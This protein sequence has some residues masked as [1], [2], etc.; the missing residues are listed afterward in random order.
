MGFSIGSLLSGLAPIAGAFLGG[1]VGLAIGT[2]V[3]SAFAPSPRRPS[4]QVGPTV[5]AASK[6]PQLL[7]KGAAGVGT[8]V[9]M[10]ELLKIARENSGRRVTSKIIRD[11]VRV[12]G[13]EVTAATFGL[14]TED[15]CRI[16]VTT[17]RR[18]S[19]GISA[20]DL[21]RTRSTIRK[22]HNITHDLRALTPRAT[23]A[24]RKHHH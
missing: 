2:A 10:G 19:R 17:G 7:L 23:T 15:I 3:G 13:I 16:A 12:C 8:V 6:I 18:R 24:R 22:V 20:V 5:R 21:R 1:P 4:S 9:T 11:S 14:S